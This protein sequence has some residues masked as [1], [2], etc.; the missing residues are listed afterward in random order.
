MSSAL[1]LASVT[2]ILKGLLENGLAERGLSGLVGGD[3]IVSTLPPDRI[4]LGTEE[5]PQLNL[6]LYQIGPNTGFRGMGLERPGG[7]RPALAP[8]A[9][10]LYYLVTGYGAEEYQSEIVL[11]HAVQ[12]LHERP[13][14]GRD[15][16]RA[17][18]QAASSTEAGRVAAPALAALA[19]SDLPEQVEQVKITPE[20]LSIEEQSRL[21]SALQ[22][23]YRPSATYKVSLVLLH[24]G[25]EESRRK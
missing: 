20:F 7:E 19:G 5:R 16:L 25:T 21:W 24:R 14:L 9:L 10:D 8:L 17:A 12:L 23:K 13:V 3:A 11:G 22:A 6:F 15:D 1:A 18:L 2:A 4:A